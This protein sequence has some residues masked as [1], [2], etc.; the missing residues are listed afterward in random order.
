MIGDFSGAE[1][2]ESTTDEPIFMIK[3]KL[4]GKESWQLYSS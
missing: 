4:R 2:E 3:T 1:E